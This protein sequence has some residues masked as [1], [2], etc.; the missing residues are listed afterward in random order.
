M[1][2]PDSTLF[3]VKKARLAG[4]SNSSF[5]NARTNNNTII[6]LFL[7]A[8]MMCFPPDSII[9]ERSSNSARSIRRDYGY[10]GLFALIFSKYEAISCFI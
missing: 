7:L 3:N 6:C 10:F 2:I 9:T 1:E 5:D 4:F 8:E